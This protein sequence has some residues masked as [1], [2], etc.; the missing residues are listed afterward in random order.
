M[1][2][3]IN[4][5]MQLGKA[6]Y[7]VDQHDAIVC[8]QEQARACFNDSP[9]T[10][11]VVVV[12]NNGMFEAAGLAYDISEFEA[13]TDPEDSRPKTFLVFPYGVAQELANYKAPTA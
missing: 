11:D 5:P 6:E 7:L 2:Y 9:P 1:G 8:T 4:T 13:F 3:Y 10:R 12:M